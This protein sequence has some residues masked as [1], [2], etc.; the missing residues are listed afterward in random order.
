MRPLSCRLLAP[1]VSSPYSSYSPKGTR[2]FY[3]P[4]WLANFRSLSASWPQSTSQLAS[5][6][7]LAEA[8]NTIM[9]VLKGWEKSRRHLRWVNPGADPILTHPPTEI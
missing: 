1:K 3:D 7:S 8:M 2:F 9:L 5:A 4:D 6:S